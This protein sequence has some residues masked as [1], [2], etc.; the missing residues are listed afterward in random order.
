MVSRQARK[1]WKMNAKQLTTNILD[2]LQSVGIRWDRYPRN[3]YQVFGA[4]TSLGFFVSHSPSGLE[5][6]LF[7]DQQDVTCD[8]REGVERILDYALNA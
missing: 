3:V 2:M 6:E 4:D 5:I 8:W 7:Y 1:G